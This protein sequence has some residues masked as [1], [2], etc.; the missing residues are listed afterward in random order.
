MSEAY[1]IWSNEHR[2]WWRPNSRGYTIHIE[3][4]GRYTR[5]DALKF[6]RVRDQV[7]GEPM[8][9]LPIREA[10]VLAIPRQPTEPM[11]AVAAVFEKAIG[12]VET[13]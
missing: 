4:A 13:A 11:A 2:A 1:L 8:P 3:A 5:D 7:P 12:K 10:D 6:S 9:E